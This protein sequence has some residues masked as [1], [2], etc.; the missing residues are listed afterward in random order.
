M[1]LMIFDVK[2]LIIPLY[3]YSLTTH[4][5]VNICNPI[6]M[7]VKGNVKIQLAAIAHATGRGCS[8][9]VAT[10]SIQINELLLIIR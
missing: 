7:Y 4:F 8:Q 9:K 3:M 1:L 10:L 6:Y 2:A 5:K